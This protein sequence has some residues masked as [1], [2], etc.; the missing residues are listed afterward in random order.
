MREGI[1][2]YG[3]GL[4]G[5]QDALIAA[6]AAVNPHTIVV[7]QTGGPVIMPWL[8]AVPAVV[9]AWYSGNGGAAAIARILFGEVNPSGRL[10]L[11]FPLAESQLPHPIITGQ[12]PDGRITPTNGT[13]TAYD[14][15]YQEGARVGYRWFEDQ[16]LAPLFPFGYGLSY[17]SFAYENLKVVGAATIKAE[18]DVRNTGTRPGKTVAQVYVKPP[19]GPTRLVGFQKVELAPGESKHVTLYADQRLIAMFDGDANLWRIADGDYTVRL[20]DSAI[21]KAAAAVVHVNAGTVKP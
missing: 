10:P 9:E 5:D 19:F 11:T 3:L 17:T 7:L 14:V 1:D 2:V 16:K 20:G 8:D 6:V 15:N 12:R 21:D 13:P 18:F 4:P